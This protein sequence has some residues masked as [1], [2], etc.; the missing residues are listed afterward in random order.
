MPIH[1]PTVM[2]STISNANNAVSLV[3]PTQGHRWLLGLSIIFL[4]IRACIPTMLGKESLAGESME[5]MEELMS[6]AYITILMVFV[7]LQSQSRD[8]KWQG[9]MTS[10]ESGDVARRTP[11]LALLLSC[12]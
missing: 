9:S 4:L 6:F 11:S 5:C 10:E 7:A 2:S 1:Q 8:W 12:L 3:T